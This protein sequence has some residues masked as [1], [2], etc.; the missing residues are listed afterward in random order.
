[1][2]TQK[3]RDGSLE[4]QKHM[5]NIGEKNIPIDAYKISLSGT[6]TMDCSG[7]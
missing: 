3:D 7:T 5:P 4:H 6:G 2:S 1:M